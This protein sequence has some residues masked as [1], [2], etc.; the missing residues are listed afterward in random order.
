MFR[1]YHLLHFYN[2]QFQRMFT[3]VN[4]VD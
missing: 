4:H 2:L 1:N 3:I